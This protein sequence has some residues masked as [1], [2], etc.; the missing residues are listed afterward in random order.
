MR[1]APRFAGS[2]AVIALSTAAYALPP[3]QLYVELT[4]PGGVL[5]PPPGEYAGP[6]VIRKS[7]TVDGG[8]E[9]T[10]DGGGDG[11]VLTI[12][13]D[14]VTLRGLRLTRSG[15]SHD[16]VDAGLQVSASNCLVEDNV[17]DD[18]LFGIHLHGANDNIIRRNRIRSRDV[19][20]TLR[21]DGIRLWYSR[22]NRIEG[23]QIERV[24][25][26]VLTN[27]PDNTLTC[28][29]V[30]DSRMGVELI[31]S[32]GNALHGNLISHGHS[33]VA[34]LYS[35]GVRVAGN[36]LEHLRE[37]SGSA[38]A[39]KDSSQVILQDNEVL[40]CAYG[41]TANAPVYPENILRLEGNR[42]AYNDVAL[43]FYGE[44]GG[45]IIHGNRFEDNMLD[46]LVSAPSSARGNDWSGNYW[47]SYQGFDRDGDGRGDTPH[48]F[49]VYADR[50][51]IDRPMARFFR[52]SPMMS[53]LDFVERLAPFSRPEWILRDPAPLTP[54][55][56]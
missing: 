25:D 3:L 2:L 52:G 6:T 29:T 18:V 11:T 43:Y 31:F 17:I 19:P 14:G 53:L 41:L 50:L 26:V 47:D 51:W 54:I 1:S 44:K 56:R 24:R 32:P 49:H 12:A 33:G 7:I 55:T 22:G 8:D 48:V 30:R 28:N 9:V 21:G 15:E 5:R 4:P 36:R 42:F 10:V 20:P 40:H 13:A 38:L 37:P 16:R 46:V 35:N 39:V 27:S 23:N 34:V 45:H